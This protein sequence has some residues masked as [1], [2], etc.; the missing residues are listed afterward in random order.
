MKSNNEKGP[1][2]SFW[3]TR[4][5]VS[6]P[7]RTTEKY[8]GNTP[9]VYF[10]YRDIKI[11]MDA[12][13]GI[14]NLGLALTER[15][16]REAAPLSL[17]LF[18]S[19][20]HWDHIQGLP[21]FQPA[22]RKDVSLAIYG[23]PRKGRFLESILKD[24]MDYEYFPVAMSEFAA[25]IR[26][27]EISKEVLE[28]GPV[29]IE[30]QEQIFHPGG[31]VRYRLNVNGKK[32][33]YTT[34]VELDLIF[35]PETESDENIKL[36]QDY[37]DFIARADFLIA[38]GQYTGEEYLSKRGWGHSSIP[39]LLDIAYMAGVKRIAVFHH[40][41]QHSDKFLDELWM[42][43]RYKFQSEEKKMELFWAREGMTLE[44]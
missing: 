36:R 8:G 31:S 9:C 24:Q 4:G 6:T 33:V 43:N 20:T 13:T 30:W 10:C 3:G 35:F 22:Y 32:I 39:V 15:L 16:E 19:H 38:D 5:S 11:I 23:S 27:H 7:G 29:I 14:R 18:L 34:D 2:I 21:F 17:H 26:I 28:L 44:V 37:L 1:L 41:P 42:Q 25:N 12:G 40:D